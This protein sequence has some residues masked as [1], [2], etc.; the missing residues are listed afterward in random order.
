MSLL[1]NLIGSAL[2]GSNS[3]GSGGGQNLLMQAAMGLITQ[4]GGIEGLAQKFQGGGLGQIFS[5]WVGTGQNQPVTPQQITQALGHEQVQQI[6]QQAGVSHDEA[7]SGLAQ[8]LP[9]IIDKLTPHGTAP[10]GNALQS[11]LAGLLSGGLGNLF[12]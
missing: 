9:S 12:K 11:G 5:S 3:T 4:H 8:M 2:G 10:T 6:A 1:G 7:A